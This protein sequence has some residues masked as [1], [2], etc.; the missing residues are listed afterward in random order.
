M[1]AKNQN[2]D[3]LLVTDGIH[4]DVNSEKSIDKVKLNNVIVST[5]FDKLKYLEKKHGFIEAL[6]DKNGNNLTFFK[7][8]SKNNWKETLSEDIREKLEVSFQ[9][10]MEELGYL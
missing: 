6:K 9:A 3:S 1:G 8:G 5:K 2:L 10:E 4:R 7:Y